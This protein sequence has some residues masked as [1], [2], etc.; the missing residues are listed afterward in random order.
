MTS[1]EDNIPQRID[2]CAPLQRAMSSLEEFVDDS[3]APSPLALAS[4]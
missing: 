1:N 4:D 3:N 2:I